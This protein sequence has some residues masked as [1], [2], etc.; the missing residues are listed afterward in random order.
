MIRPSAL[1]LLRVPDLRTLVLRIYPILSSDIY[2]SSFPLELCFYPALDFVQE[3]I[4][5][6]FYLELVPVV[7]PLLP[8]IRKYFRRIPT[9]IQKSF[10][11]LSSYP[12]LQSSS[13]LRPDFTITPLGLHLKLR[14]H[15]QT[16][17]CLVMCIDGELQNFLATATSAKIIGLPSRMQVALGLGLLLRECKQVIKYEEDEVTLETP[18]YVGASILDIKM[19]DL[20][21]EA[22]EKQ[23]PAILDKAAHKDGLE[24]KDSADEEEAVVEVKGKKAMKSGGSGKPSKKAKGDV[25]RSS[26]TRQP[27]TSGNSHIP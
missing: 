2:G 17:P 24:T 21:I 22:V 25:R 26:R 15:T 12:V 16:T 8:T 5:H 14:A 20:V 7:L 18:T 10:G 27:T 11:A 1:P 9:L 23:E 6:P 19:L 13:G 3:S 4:L